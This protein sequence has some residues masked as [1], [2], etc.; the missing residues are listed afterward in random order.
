MQQHN[1]NGSQPQPEAVSLE[2][3]I[4]WE[5]KLD[6]RSDEITELY[7]DLQGQKVYFQADTSSQSFGEDHNSVKGANTKGLI[8]IDGNSASDMLQYVWEATEP[9]RRAAHDEAGIPFN[10]EGNHEG[11]V[12]KTDTPHQPQHQD[13]PEVGPG[14]P[15]AEEPQ[16][17][18]FGPT[19]QIGVA[20]FTQFQT[21]IATQTMVIDS[22]SVLLES[23]LEPDAPEH[24]LIGMWLKQLQQLRGV[25]IDEGSH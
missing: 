19:M 20:D 2:N 12:L 10:D 3:L 13:A 24:Q 14:P 17:S 15:P 1:A 4:Q 23:K 21:L 9:L 22:L 11:P 25:P 5:V 18:A 16:M 6:P 7:Y 8:A